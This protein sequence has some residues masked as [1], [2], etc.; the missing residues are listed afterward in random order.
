M[1]L[2]APTATAAPTDFAP[3]APPL[4]REAALFLDFDGTLVA[5]APRP[6]AVVVEP[7][8]LPTLE[9][10]RHALGGAV[11]LVSGRRLVE[12]DRFLAPLQLPAAGIHGIEWRD[13]L[14]AL[15]RQP[16]ELPRTVKLRAQ[17]LAGL[18][19][20]LRVE[21]KQAALALH[22][23]QAPQ[24][25]GLCLRSLKSAVRPYPDWMVLLGKCV[26]EVKPAGIDKASALRELRAG[27]PFA[28]RLPIFVGDDA[29][30]ED[31]F[32]AAQACG[33]FG[34]KVGAGASC[35][36]FRLDNPQAVRRWLE[37]SLAA[38]DGAVAVSPAG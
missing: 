20:G 37:D 36:R 27:E 31:G 30:D 17:R 12:L 38:L 14:G 9:R 25:G 4:P 2:D 24:L 23:R 10:L 13:A 16:L 34:V 21:D 11:A 7:W 8:L 32:A 33:G 15:H 6:D 5:I 35:A 3:P 29:T 22:W 28:R 18:H 19:P 26:A 1:N